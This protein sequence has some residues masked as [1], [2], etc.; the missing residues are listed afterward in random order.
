MMG[1][2]VF[3]ILFMLGVGGIGIPN[4]L[5]SYI[6]PESY[7]RSRQ[8]TVTVE[9]M[10]ELAGK[11]PTDAKGQV[12]RLLAIRMLGEE[13]DEVK[14][15]KEAI[16]KV[17]EPLTKGQEGPGF[18]RAYA[19]QTLLRLGVKVAPAGPDAGPK[20]L[21]G[22]G[23]FPDKVNLVAGGVRA[24]P[25]VE[26]RKD[27]PLRDFLKSIPPQGIEELYKFV[28]AVGNVRIDRLT[29]A[30]A[31]EPQ[32]GKGRIFFRIT[33]AA[34]HKRLAEFFAKQAGLTAKEE[35]GPGGESITIFNTGGFGPSVA[36]V[37]DSDF[38]IAGS[39]GGQGNH[40][41]VLEQMLKVR[42]GT[43]PNALKGPL[44]AELKKVPAQVVSLVLGE[45]PAEV[46]QGLVVGGPF[47]SAPERINV[48]VMRGQGGL[49]LSFRGKFANA[50]GA[51]AFADSMATLRKQGLE[52]LK[53]PPPLPP[54]VKIPAKAFEMMRASLESLKME[55]KDDVVAGG[56]QVPG[57]LVN[58]MPLLMGY[59]VVGRDVAPMPT[60]P[61]VVPAPA[62]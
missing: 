1:I 61:K 22:F 51:K 55:P 8:V 13:P 26:T 16:L 46:R 9:K 53:T 32:P 15:E 39:D 34:D 59:A 43:Q 29:F 20:L 41:E 24:A 52:A 33:G 49:D 45:V 56:M 37:G 17:L 47:Q 11:Q 60:A 4:D 62:K 28:E 6:D 14:K 3:P 31:A 58:L 12:A 19:R 40:Q 2:T 44:A 50:A 5:V 30:Y 7:F 38:L 21:D 27:N 25:G 36:L 42:A 23:W 18:T 48:Q 57:E 54:G 10:L 35:K